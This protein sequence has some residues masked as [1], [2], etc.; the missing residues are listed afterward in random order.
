MKSVIFNKVLNFFRN[1]QRV[2][3]HKHFVP[4]KVYVSKIAKIKKVVRSAALV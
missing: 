3:K 2:C 4:T 1:I